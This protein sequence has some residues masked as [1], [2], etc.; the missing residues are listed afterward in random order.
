[1]EGDTPQLLFKIHAI[2][3]FKVLDGR[4]W[5]FLVP[6]RCR[7]PHNLI[8]SDVEMSKLVREKLR[9]EWTD[10]VVGVISKVRQ[11][12]KDVKKIRSLMKREL[13]FV[14]GKTRV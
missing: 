8:L 14:E 13:G 5:S 6:W 7:W 9:K 10:P 3:I 12:F 2:A 4:S 11:G 1:M